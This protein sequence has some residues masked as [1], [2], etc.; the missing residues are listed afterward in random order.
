[1]NE[2][3]L[4]KEQ[5]YALLQIASKKLGTTPTQMAESFNKGG[6]DGLTAS[7]SPENASRLQSFIGDRGRAEQ[8][9]NSPKAQEVIRQLL[10]KRQG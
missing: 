3:A 8:L 2:N 4:T 9:L 10:E 5:M 6:L 7:L 1:M